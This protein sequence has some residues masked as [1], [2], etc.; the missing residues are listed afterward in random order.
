MRSIPPDRIL[1]FFT[2]ADKITDPD[3]LARYRSVLS[4]EEIQ[5]VNR[6]RFKKDRI[7][8]L[9]AR[10][11]LRYL[12]SEYTGLAPGS[13]SFKTNEFG[14]PSLVPGRSGPDI[15]F[16]LS[17]SSGTVVC[18]LMSGHDIGVDV[19]SRDRSVDLAISRRFFSRQEADQVDACADHE[20][21]SRFFD[22]W[23][24]K[25][26]YIKACGKGLSIPLDSFSFDLDKPD[27][28]IRFHD[29]GVAGPETLSG[30]QF[31]RWVPENRITV[32]A[33]AQSSNR[34]GIDTY[35]CIPFDRI[36]QD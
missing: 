5:K 4:E 30:W 12:L 33:C 18:G 35:H 2:R 36:W 7:L 6:Y 9:T 13:F 31:F 24:L 10:A 17:H 25:E 34:L 20:K 16:N 14:K 19:E 11:L 27:I 28:N 29:P 21:H 32:A 3:L 23:T 8:S 15:R 22:L 1:L 26:S